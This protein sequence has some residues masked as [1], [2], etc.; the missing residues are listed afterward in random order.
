MNKIADR[1]FLITILFIL[2]TLWITYLS[3][4]IILALILA[5]ILCLVIGLLIRPR[6]IKTSLKVDEYLPKLC[7][8]TNKELSDILLKV[9]SK[10]IHPK[11]SPKGLITADNKMLIFPMLKMREITA[12]EICKLSESAKRLNYNKIVL[13]VA[14]YDKAGYDKIKPYLATT[15]EFLDI[16]KVLFALQKQALLPEINHKKKVKQRFIT[17]FKNA[18]KRKNGKYFLLTGLSTAFLSIFTPLTLYYLIFST[19]MLATSICCYL[20]KSEQTPSVLN[21]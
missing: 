16:E 1:I 21:N 9:I 8:M 2:F 18:T 12:D 20:K 13:I 4:N 6:K 5:S 15:V 19:L 7:V 14:R 3:K 10:D 17:L 11:V